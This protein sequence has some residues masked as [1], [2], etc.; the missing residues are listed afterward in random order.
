MS[1]RQNIKTAF[2]SG[3]ANTYSS[4]L[5]KSKKNYISAKHAGSQKAEEDMILSS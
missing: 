1:E 3:V 5:W 4:T 2:P